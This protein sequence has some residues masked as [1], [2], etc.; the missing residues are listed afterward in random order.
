MEFIP[1]IYFLYS[2][3]QKQKHDNV[4]K[5]EKLQQQK[6]N[7]PQLSIEERANHEG[8]PK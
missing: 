5:D 2:T 7:S 4:K 6:K 1:Q 3:A 8:N